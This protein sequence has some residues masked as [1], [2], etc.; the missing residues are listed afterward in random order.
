MRKLLRGFVGKTMWQ[1]ETATSSSRKEEPAAILEMVTTFNVV[2]EIAA[3]GPFG[4]TLRRVP[5]SVL[6][7]GGLAA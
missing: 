7:V 1:K 3:G 2:K 6:W 5:T 4:T